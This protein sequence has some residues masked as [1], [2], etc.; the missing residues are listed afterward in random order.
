MLSTLS[1]IGSWTPRRLPG[2]V[3][4]FNATRNS[5]ILDGS[6]EVA[7]WVGALGNTVSGAGSAPDWK[8]DGWG[9]NVPS[10]GMQ[11]GVTLLSS[12]AAALVTPGTGTDVPF[13]LFCSVR[14]TVIEDSTI[15]CWQDSVNSSLSSLNLVGAGADT[16]IR[17]RR[18]DAATNSVDVDSSM[19]T[20]VVRRRLG[21][22]F[23]GT[24]VQIFIDR[25]LAASSG[26]NVGALSLD[27]FKIGSGP[28]IDSFTGDIADIV[29]MN[30]LVSVAD[31]LAYESWSR[32]ALG[33]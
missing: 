10:L 25:T 21:V 4:W 22:L 33:T 1:G 12:T 5:V 17:Y 20:G 3:E 7:T 23:D 19:V 24:A 15:V 9:Q 8:P 13:S 32:K 18:T 28:G 14:H 16:I 11:A 27:T 26:S 31:Y 30:R 6:G 29:I 2:L